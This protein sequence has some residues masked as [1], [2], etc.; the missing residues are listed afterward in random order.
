[1][2]RIVCVD[3]AAET[4]GHASRVATTRS[5]G[6]RRARLAWCCRR[7][8]PSRAKEHSR[9]ERRSVGVRRAGSF[10]ETNAFRT[11]AAVHRFVP[12]IVGTFSTFS[13]TAICSSDIRFASI[14]LIF[15]RQM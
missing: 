9:A 1:M 4:H 8:C 14:A 15:V 12:W 10:Y 6:T 2:K 13:C 5:D 11:D 3:R 7:F